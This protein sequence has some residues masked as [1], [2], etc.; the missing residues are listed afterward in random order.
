MFLIR[1]RWKDVIRYAYLSYFIIYD[2]LRSIIYGS[3]RNDSS[4]S[5]RT[6]TNRIINLIHY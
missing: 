4:Y 1:K 5:A 6:T 3:L 2:S